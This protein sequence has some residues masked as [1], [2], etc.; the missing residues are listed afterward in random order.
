MS[1]KHPKGRMVRLHFVTPATDIPLL[2][3]Q[4]C[5]V[6]LKGQCHEIF[7]SGFFH[8]LSPPKPLKIT[9][10]S[11]RLFR[12]FAEVFASQGAPTVSMTPVANLPL[13]STMPT[14]ASEEANLCKATV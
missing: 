2:N 11:L 13:V 14:I 6:L 3:V 5:F 9:L 12:K 1:S 4:G 8:E 7:A 10:G